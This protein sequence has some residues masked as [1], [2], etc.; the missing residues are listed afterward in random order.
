ML[1]ASI[2][3][4]MHIYVRRMTISLPF[5]RKQVIHILSYK[6]SYQCL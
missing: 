5:S 1:P 6:F 3:Q 4:K 2:D